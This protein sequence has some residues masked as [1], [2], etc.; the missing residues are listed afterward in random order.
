MSPD[1]SRQDAI[2]PALKGGWQD[3]VAPRQ[4]HVA[5][6]GLWVMCGWRPRV[7]SFDARSLPLLTRT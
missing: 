7:A 2:V 4:T 5:L 6:G 1:T 3:H